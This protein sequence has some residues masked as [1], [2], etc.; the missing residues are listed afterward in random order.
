[1]IS[2]GFRGADLGGT[3]LP[4]ATSLRHVYGTIYSYLASVICKT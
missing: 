2:F 3:T 1:M 4:L